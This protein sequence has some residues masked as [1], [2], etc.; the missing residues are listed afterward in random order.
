MHFIANCSISYVQVVGRS[1]SPAFGVEILEP[2]GKFVLKNDMKHKLHTH[3]SL[4]EDEP[5]E[6][7]A[8]RL[9]R[10][11]RDLQHIVNLLQG[12]VVDVEYEF[13]EEENAAWDAD[14]L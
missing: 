6:I 4:P 8:D 10:R 5:G 13:G 11:L 7:S 2:S 3:P 14:D 1:L 12:N 9:Q